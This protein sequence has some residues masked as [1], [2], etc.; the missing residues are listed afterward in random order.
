[1]FRQRT[2]QNVAINVGLQWFN[3]VL[4][5]VTKVVLVRLLIPDDFGIFA[6]AAG[7]IGFVG[8]FG[9]FGLDYAII[10]KHDQATEKDYDVGMTL[11]ILIA[12]P[13]FVVSVLVAGPW[14][15]F[16]NS[17]AVAPT[18]QVM[19]LVYLLGVWTFVPGVHLTSELNY[20]SIAI[21]S[22]SGQLANSLVAVGLA[23]GGFGVWAL[24][25]GYVAAS[26]TSAIVYSFVRRWRFRLS[27]KREVAR[28]LL[29]YARYLVWA[30]VL[31]FLI[32]NIDNFTVGYLWGTTQLGYY[33]VA[34]AY[35][36]LPVSMFSSPA[37]GALFPSLTKVQ[38]DIDKLRQGYLDSY[39]YTMAIIAPAAIGMAVMAPEVVD[40]LFGPV[41]IAATVPLLILSFYGLF[42]AQVDFSSSLYAAV[43]RPRLI[44]E[45][46]LYILLLSLIPLFP[47]TIW[48]GIPG[49]AVAMTVPVAFVAGISIMKS[50]DILR[51]SSR[52]FLARLRGPLLAAEAMGIVVFGIRSLL[53][54]V[55]PA[56]VGLP[57]L[58][59]GLSANTIVLV[60]GIAVGMAAYFAFLRAADRATYAGMRRTLGF[61]LRRNRT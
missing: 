17:S 39:G 33:A 15:S 7:L 5:V 43:G 24:V 37:G 29:G 25:Y 14:A 27:F 23:L 28:P 48:Y 38:E 21:P 35:G 53:Y 50:A 13:L 1:M 26:A 18:T 31:A 45:L 61:V 60:A 6:L 42:R 11:R 4:S 49:T 41:W 9:N 34:Y 56:R 57:L 22:I 44:A 54:A 55:L 58:S 3:R 8:T 47:L 52:T 20:R 16:F 46:N 30:A 32:T 10:Q 51:G 36:Y 19:A 12:I 2:A 59:R 40:I